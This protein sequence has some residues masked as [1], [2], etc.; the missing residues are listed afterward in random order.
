MML[1]NC[2]ITNEGL[3]LLVGDVMINSSN[4]SGVWT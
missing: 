4:K 1:N 2:A 3:W